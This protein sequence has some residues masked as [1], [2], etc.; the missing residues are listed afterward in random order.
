MRFKHS[1]LYFP[2]GLASVEYS[3]EFCILGLIITYKWAHTM[4]V[5][6]SLGYIIQNDI[7]QFHPFACKIHDV[8]VLIAE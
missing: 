4:H 8:L 7:I 5:I 2:F 3:M 6:L 1:L